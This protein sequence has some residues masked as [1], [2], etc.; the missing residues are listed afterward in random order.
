MRDPVARWLR[1]SNKCET[2]LGAVC[3]RCNKYIGN[4]ASPMSDL[5]CGCG[6]TT[7]AEEVALAHGLP[8]GMFGQVRTPVKDLRKAA[9]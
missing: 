9:Q 5:Q 7:S 6:E 3:R 1:R 8:P 4:D 2:V